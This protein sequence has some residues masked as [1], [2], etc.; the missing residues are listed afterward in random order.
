MSHA[1]SQAY[2]KG[3]IL[4]ATPGELV[5]LL[6]DGAKRFLRQATVS[7]RAGE[8]ERAHHALRRAEMII[9]HLDG[10]L[11]DEQGEISERLHGIY[12][13]CLTQLL[14]ARLEQE[15]ARIDEVAGL[16]TELRGAWE[17]AANEMARA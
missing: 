9:T 15:A 3:A 1:P 6:Y 11:D 10:T 5:V 13:F 17:Q 4:A 12:A 16:L 8:I 2:R 7:I 14:R